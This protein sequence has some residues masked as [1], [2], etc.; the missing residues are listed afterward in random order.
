M[1]RDANILT[2]VENQTS[3]TNWRNGMKTSVEPLQ[4]QADVC[5][6]SESDKMEKYKMEKNNRKSRNSSL[7]EIMSQT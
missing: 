3:W 5:A 7:W 2:G 6:V 1:G 4:F